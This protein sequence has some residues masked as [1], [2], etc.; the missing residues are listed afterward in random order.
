MG[1]G[2]A[3]SDGSSGDDRIVVNK[4]RWS[5]Q[6][7]GCS[8]TGE[9]RIEVQG[10]DVAFSMGEEGTAD[11]EGTIESHGWLD[12]ADRVSAPACDG[13]EALPPLSTYGF[14]DDRSATS[15]VYYETECQDLRGRM[16]SHTVV[17]TMAE[18]GSPPTPRTEL[19]RLRAEMVDWIE[20]N[21]HCE[22]ASDCDLLPLVRQDNCNHGALAYSTVVGDQDELQS[23]F[24][25][26]VDIRETSTEPESTWCA[27]PLRR[28]CVENRCVRGEV[29]IP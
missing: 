10:K 12:F 20:A 29:Y 6:Y 5:F 9:A 22:Q 24:R 13:C 14:Y 16:Q 7:A 15:A 19:P 28:W 18:P 21:N 1:C 8:R 11:L 3:E 2:G 27:N 23:L 17:V 25:K 4:G 26:Y